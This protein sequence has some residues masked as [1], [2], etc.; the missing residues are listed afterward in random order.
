MLAVSS[1]S[2]ALQNEKGNQ[3]KI[4][5]AV[6]S[7]CPLDSPPPPALSPPNA[8]PN[9]LRLSTKEMHSFLLPSPSHDF[10]SFLKKKKCTFQVTKYFLPTSPLATCFFFLLL[11]FFLL[12]CTAKQEGK[13]KAKKHFLIRT[14]KK[15]KESHERERERSSRSVFPV[16]I[17]WRQL[18]L[19]HAI[20]RGV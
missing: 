5:F 7:R 15:T 18:A 17:K 3:E 9:C 16:K 6:P 13:G 11:P 19:E 12:L 10:S 2:L 20:W 1:S 8:H 14:K 4:F